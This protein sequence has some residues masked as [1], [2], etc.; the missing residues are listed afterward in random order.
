MKSE[1]VGGP[2]AASDHLHIIYQKI[3]EKGPITISDLS[4]EFPQIS[5]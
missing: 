3:C 4:F 5:R 1:E 2:S